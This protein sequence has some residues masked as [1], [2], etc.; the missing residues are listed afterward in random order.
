MLFEN[1]KYT[2]SAI[3][4]DFPRDPFSIITPFVATP[5][6]IFF[7]PNMLMAQPSYGVRNGG[8]PRDSGHIVLVRNR[9]DSSVQWRSSA[10][11]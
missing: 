2:P 1:V 3:G 7:G 6:K 9:Y 10:A 5:V 11:G 8:Q 4:F